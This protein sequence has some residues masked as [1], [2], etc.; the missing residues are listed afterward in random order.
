MKPQK[1]NW[2]N[3]KWRPAIGWLYITICVFDF[4]I[5]PIF[6]TVW[7]GYFVSGVVAQQ[8]AP[9]TLGA[10]GLFHMSMGAIL[11]VTSWSRGKEKIG[12]VAGNGYP[13]SAL[14]T[15]PS[16]GSHEGE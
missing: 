7:Q 1:E 15:Q 12:G 10:G 11:G 5:G 3:N 16:R 9:L 2:I 13:T 6:W 14:N 4:I 8:W